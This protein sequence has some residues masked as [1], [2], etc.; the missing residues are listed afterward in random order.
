MI[1]FWPIQSGLLQQIT[2]FVVAQTTELWRLCN[3]RTGQSACF[4]QGHLPA[5]TFVKEWIIS[6]EFLL[7][8]ALIP[9]SG[10]H[11]HV[12]IPFLRHHLLRL[13]LWGLGPHICVWVGTQPPI[14]RNVLC[15]SLLTS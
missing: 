15:H 5:V 6:L 11:L 3:L 8:R 2:E 12:L 14:L 7:L 1:H 4:G 13:S 9:L 10:L